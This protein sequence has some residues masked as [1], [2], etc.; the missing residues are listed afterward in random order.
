MNILDNPA[1]NSWEAQLRLRFGVYEGK[2][3]LSER[4][5]VGPLVVQKSLYPEGK[6]VCQVLIIHPPGGIAGGDRLDMEFSVE[7]GAR[8]QLT[9]PGAAKWYCGFGRTA[10]QM[11]QIQVAAGAVAEWLP[12]E[13]IIF[14]GADV[15][16]QFVV[17]CEKQGVFCGWEFTT[18][19]REAG[20]EPFLSGRLSQRIELR[21]N[22]YPVFGERAVITPEVLNHDKALLNSYRS[23]GAMY[24][25]G[26]SKNSVTQEIVKALSSEHEEVGITWIDEVLIA[27]WVGTH[28][29]EGRAILAQVWSALR[30]QYFG[31][32]AQTPRIWN[33]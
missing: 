19:G 5:H 22:S 17:D 29:E 25:I 16:S 10:K 23:F 15:D 1:L 14:D 2:S 8:A 24:L 28:V 26:L 30:Q 9:T 6:D 12:Q 32:P 3:F 11:I 27:R 13:N 4:H 20:D 7:S 18:L 33:T 31:R 21:Q